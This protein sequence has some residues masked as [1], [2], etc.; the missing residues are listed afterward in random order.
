MQYDPD[1]EPYQCNDYILCLLPQIL[2]LAARYAATPAKL[3]QKSHQQI[4]Q[5]G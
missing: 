1:Q 5:A 4:L 2:L 3:Y